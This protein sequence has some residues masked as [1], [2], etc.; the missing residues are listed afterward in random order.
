[1]ES[2]LSFF[3]M[4]WDHEPAWHPS[5]CPLPARRGEGGRR[6]GEGR[7][8]ESS[9]FLSDLLTAHEPLS[10]V[11]FI[12]NELCVRFMRRAPTTFPSRIGTVNGRARLRR[13][14]ISI[15]TV[16]PH[17]VPGLSLPVADGLL[18]P[19]PGTGPQ[20]EDRR[21]VFPALTK[22]GM[23]I[24][25]LP[26]WGHV[27]LSVNAVTGRLSHAYAPLSPCRGRADRVRGA[28]R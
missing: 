8:M 25:L 6:P 21:F 23:G 10:I 12:S 18:T 3:R 19:E 2:P 5:P 26:I 11:S 20:D 1:M 9:V 27:L 15:T 22:N 7:F 17:S 4:H 16:S 28:R 14:P 13:A 24:T